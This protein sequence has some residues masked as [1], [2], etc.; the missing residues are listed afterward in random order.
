MI[1]LDLDKNQPAMVLDLAKVPDLKRIKGNLNWDPHPLYRDSVSQGY[2]LDFFLFGV[3]ADGKIAGGGDVAYFKQKMHAS[4][5]YGVPVDN[6]TGGGDDDEYFFTELDKMPANIDQLHVYVFIHEAAKRGQSFGMVA[7]T[8]VDL[9][10]A[11]TGEV[12]VRYLINQ[13]F[14][15]ETCLHVAT[16]ARANGGWEIRPIGDGAV[17]DPNEVL[18]VYC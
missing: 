14:T 5:A 8:Q 2:D 1:V 12:K 4:G 3:G 11:D 6:Q 7:N 10:D 16:I 9:S 18:S 15:N 17:A 13:Q